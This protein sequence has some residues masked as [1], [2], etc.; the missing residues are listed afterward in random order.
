MRGR[1]EAELDSLLAQDIVEPG[2][3]APVV[4]VFKLDDTVKVLC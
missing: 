1:V 3:A 4:P 2:W